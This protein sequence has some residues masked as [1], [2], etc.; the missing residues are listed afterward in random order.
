MKKVL[1]FALSYLAVNMSVAQSDKQLT[2]YM[3]DKMSFNPATT[4]FKGYCATAIYRG[5]WDKVENAPNTMLL[6]FQG[7]LPK[8]NSGVGLSFMNDVIGLGTE[9]NITLNY[10]YHYP[11]PGMG[12]LSAGVGVGVANVGFDPKWNAPM[13]GTD[14][15]LDPSLPLQSSGTGLDVNFGL[16]W[17]G[18]NLPYFIG[19]S[20]TH[21]TQPTLANVN[22]TKA[23]NY[24]IMA[25]YDIKNIYPLPANLTITPS[26]LFKTDGTAGITDI[27]VLGDYW[28]GSPGSGAAGVY[29]GL[30]YRTKDAFAIMV[31]FQKE[32]IVT[33]STAANGGMLKGS[34]D[35]LKVGY[36]YDVMTNKVLG[37][38]GAGSHELVFNYC[39]FAPPPPVQRYGNVFILQ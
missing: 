6:N 29:A 4:G 10:A 27:N 14:V 1:L 35:V 23:R 13:T 25:G 33:G 9:M 36:S 24:Y 30:T 37:Q 5:Q 31:G 12:Y 7:S 2:H 20:A 22:F 21:L 38:Y 15:S 28:F 32:L 11:V 34:P 3:F 19:V 26:V 18:M 16:H 8:I 17:K 39:V